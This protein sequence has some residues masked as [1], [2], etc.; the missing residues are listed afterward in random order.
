MAVLA[1]KTE[2]KCKL[3]KHPDRAAIDAL[4]ERRSNRERGD[5]GQLLFTLDVVL[6]T[7]ADWG[8]ENP[9]EENVKNHW[10]KHCEIVKGETAL[11][12]QSA[13]LAAADELAQGGSHVDVDDTLRSIVTLG[14]AS[15]VE[16][17]ARGENPITVDHILKAADAL[18]RRSHNEAQR[19]VLDALAG[20]I[21]KALAGAVQP[22]LLNDG[23]VI[24]VEVI[25]EAEA[26]HV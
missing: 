13:A 26:V 14:R 3:C 5:D 16:R 15:L 17:I 21:G 23:E 1:T 24:D 12:A 4:L 22:K 2:P 9:N 18:T 7:L 6:A 20:G 11:A 19:E 10:R 8:V 25:E